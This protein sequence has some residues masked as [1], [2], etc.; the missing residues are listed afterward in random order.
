MLIKDGVYLCRQCHSI[1]KLSISDTSPENEVKCD[2]CGSPDIV[3]LPSWAPLGSNLYQDSNEWEYECQH[4]KN[5]FKM[6]VPSYPSQEK[7]IKCPECG[8]GHIHRLTPIGG[9]PLY[10]G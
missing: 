4:C 2:T 6:P 3:E 5:V 10:C 8:E 7:E 9:E 1:S